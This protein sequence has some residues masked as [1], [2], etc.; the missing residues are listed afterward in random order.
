MSKKEMEEEEEETTTIEE[1]KSCGFSCLM[2]SGEK[3]AF[4]LF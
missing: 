3:Y 2:F 4:F 1:D